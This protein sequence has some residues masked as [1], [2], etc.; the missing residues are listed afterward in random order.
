MK[1]KFDIDLEYARMHANCNAQNSSTETYEDIIY[2][3]DDIRDADKLLDDFM[4]YLGSPGILVLRDTSDNIIVLNMNHISDMI[5]H[6]I[7]VIE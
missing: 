2:S 6:D 7:E 5:I 3:R 4:L 1:I